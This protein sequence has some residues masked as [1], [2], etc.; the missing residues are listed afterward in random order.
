[1]NDASFPT[2]QKAGRIAEADVGFT[3]AR[4]GY[5]VSMPAMRTRP[6]GCSA[7]V[8][9]TYSDTYDLIIDGKTPGQ[10]W[11]IEVKSR[12][13]NFS[14]DPKEYPYDTAFVCAR[15]SYRQAEAGTRAMP[16]AWIIVSQKTGAKLC[17]LESTRPLWT[18]VTCYDRARGTRD[19]FLAVRREDML[20]WDE[21]TATM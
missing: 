18:D 13:L 14:G 3:F 16:Y 6:E 19:T 4:M 1:M 11:V 8:R 5:G 7:A 17:V 21:L 2:R 12:T 20:T 9:A 10:H 15:R